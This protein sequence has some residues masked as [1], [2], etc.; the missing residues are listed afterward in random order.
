MKRRKFTSRFASLK[1]S[2]Q[3]MRICHLLIGRLLL[4][5]MDQWKISCSKVQGDY[6]I[7]LKRRKKVKMRWKANARRIL[8]KKNH[9]TI[10][11]SGSSSQPKEWRE[12]CEMSM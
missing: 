11:V 9:I 10:L 12:E 1:L 2:P 3:I 5:M 7:K 8:K 6:G 4:K